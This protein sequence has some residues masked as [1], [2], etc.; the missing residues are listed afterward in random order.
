MNIYADESGSINNKIGK[1]FVIALV[2]VL[3][4]KKL[5]TAFK[6]FISSNMTKLQEL[7][8]DFYNSNGTLTKKGGLMFKDG[9]FREIKGSQLN[10]QMKTDF[11]NYLAKKKYKSLTLI[12]NIYILINVNSK[13]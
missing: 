3:D 4:F 9:K 11:V 7:D 2:H 8:K 1:P 13:S 12:Q 10:Q 5:N 6:R